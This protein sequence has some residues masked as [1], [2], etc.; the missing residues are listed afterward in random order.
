MDRC[1]WG[2]GGERREGVNKKSG[3]RPYDPD[4]SLLRSCAKGFYSVYST[5]IHMICLRLLRKLRFC[6]I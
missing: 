3:Y 6:E 4:L 5:A 2:G 1:G